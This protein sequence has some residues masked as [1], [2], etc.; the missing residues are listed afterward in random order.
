[1]NANVGTKE[2]KSQ[3]WAGAENRT[4]VRADGGAAR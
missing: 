2:A 3:T 4:R 1:M